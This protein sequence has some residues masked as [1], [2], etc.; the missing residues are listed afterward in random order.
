M[1]DEKPKVKRASYSYTNKSTKSRLFFLQKKTRLLP[2]SATTKNDQQ[3]MMRLTSLAINQGI[4]IDRGFAYF[5]SRNHKILIEQL[6][7]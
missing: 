4:N 5:R 6:T 7:L 1:S 2:L 3:T